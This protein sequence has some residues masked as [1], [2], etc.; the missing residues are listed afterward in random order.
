[1]WSAQLSI[2]TEAI[3]SYKTNPGVKDLPQPGI[4]PQSPQSSAMSYNNP[5]CCALKFQ[6][7]DT[8][9]AKKP[10]VKRIIHN[11]EK[12]LY[13]DT[14][15]TKKFL[16]IGVRV[17]LLCW[18]MQNHPRATIRQPFYK[19]MKKCPTRQQCHLRQQPFYGWTH[20]QMGEHHVVHPFAKLSVELSPKTKYH[21][22][23]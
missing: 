8:K 4:E 21:K 7:L 14:Q 12:V 13:N 16:C 22:S 9:V 17:C 10:H 11:Q 5:R 15:A 1:V 3:S 19:L 2:L 20:K 23:P 6:L 18:K